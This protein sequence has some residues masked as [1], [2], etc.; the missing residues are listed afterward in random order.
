MGTAPTGEITR[1]LQAWSAGDARALHL[2]T[3]HVY[4]ELHRIASGQMRRQRD[5]QT[6]QTHAL[7]HEAYLHLMGAGGADW[8]DRAHFFAVAAQVMR[9]ILVD[10]ARRRSTAKR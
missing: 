3:P 1:L 5:G 8:Q 4:G 6:L 10:A 7:I 9:R 2:L